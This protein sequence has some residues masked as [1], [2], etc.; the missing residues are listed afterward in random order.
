M[1]GSAESSGAV[2]RVKWVPRGM[3]ATCHKCHVAVAVD[4]ENSVAGLGSNV[5]WVM[6][7][8]SRPELGCV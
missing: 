8:S 3:I 4:S 5:Q 1:T 6:G 2:V 7:E